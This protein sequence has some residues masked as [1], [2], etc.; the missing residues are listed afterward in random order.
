MLEDQ[1]KR[2]EQ[3][4]TKLVEDIDRKYIR[5]MQVVCYEVMCASKLYETT[6]DLLFK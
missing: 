3:L 1:G 5:I 4:M 2:V 6:H